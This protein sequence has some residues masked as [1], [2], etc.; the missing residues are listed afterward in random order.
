MRGINGICAARMRS[1]DEFIERIPASA[2][3]CFDA[4]HCM[5]TLQVNPAGAAS[6]AS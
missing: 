5:T 6:S 2:P 1:A 3:L 4:V